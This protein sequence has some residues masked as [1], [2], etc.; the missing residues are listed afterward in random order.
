MTLAV[1]G[2][3]RKMR[4]TVSSLQGRSHHKSSPP[5]RR[6]EGQGRPVGGQWRPVEGQGH[7][8]EGQ[9][10]PVGGRGRPVGGQGH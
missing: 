6:A 9:G 8:V 5:L 1:R 3:H 2:K 4:V 10:R 7:P